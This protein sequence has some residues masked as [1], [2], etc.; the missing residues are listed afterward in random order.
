MTRVFQIINRPLLRPTNSRQQSLNDD[1]S[2][3]KMQLDTLFPTNAKLENYC[4][5]V[6]NCAPKNSKRDHTDLR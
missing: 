5:T 1:F 2:F 4:E 6:L 3:F